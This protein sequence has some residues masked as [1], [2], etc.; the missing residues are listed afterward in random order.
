MPIR[1]SSY[2]QP[3]SAPV[4]TVLVPVFFSEYTSGIVMDNCL[5][6]IQILYI[7]KWPHDKKKGIGKK[8]SETKSPK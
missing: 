8:E 4:G 7:V 6:S 2:G 1:V 5:K 3:N